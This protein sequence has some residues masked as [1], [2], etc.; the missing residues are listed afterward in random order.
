MREHSNVSDHERRF[1]AVLTN[2]SQEI[3][4]LSLDASNY[5]FFYLQ[6]RSQH[7][8]PRLWRRFHLLWFDNERTP[9]DVIAFC[10]SQFRPIL[11]R[12][13][14]WR[15]RLSIHIHWN[16]PNR[17]SAGCAESGNSTQKFEGEKFKVVGFIIGKTFA[18][19]FSDKVTRTR[20]TANL[21][22]LATSCW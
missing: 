16:A 14:R 3:A 15:G 13:N 11:A 5:N 8:E 21:A 2:P 4:V 18:F 7:K 17:E 9:V 10:G 19:C 22:V 12:W 20:R 6:R 1:R